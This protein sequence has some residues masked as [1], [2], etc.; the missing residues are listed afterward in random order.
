MYVD[1][2]ARN[3]TNLF[4]LIFE[5]WDFYRE[6]EVAQ[7]FVSER[8]ETAFFTLVDYYNEWGDFLEVRKHKFSTLDLFFPYKLCYAYLKMLTEAH[9]VSW[10]EEEFRQEAMKMFWSKQQL[11]D[12]FKILSSQIEER[13]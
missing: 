4:P 1:R 5:K 6:I 2:I 10:Y 3:N 11:K 9:H 13:G 8:P 12:L 7:H